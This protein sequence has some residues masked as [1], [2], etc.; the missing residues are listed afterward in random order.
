VLHHG[1]V[2]ASVVDNR[3]LQAKLIK[4]ATLKAYP[5]YPRGMLTTHAD[6]INPDLLA[7]IKS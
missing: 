5:G 3:W 2:I 4:N 7:F 1:Y 6:A